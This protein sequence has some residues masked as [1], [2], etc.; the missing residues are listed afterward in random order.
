MGKVTMRQALTKSLNV[1][2]IKFAE[3]VGYDKVVELSQRLGLNEKIKPYPAI[4]LGSFEITPLEM[5]RAYTAFA[6]HGLLSELSPMLTIRDESGQQIYKP[7][8][9]QKQALTPQVAFM[10]TSLLQSVIDHGTGAGAR[11][12]GFALPAAGKT[13]TSRDGWF[14]GY[15]P[16]LLCIVWVGFDD[17]SE[18]NLSGAQSALPIWTEFMKKA[19]ILRP[20]KGESFVPPEGVNEVE[21]DPVTGLLATEACQKREKE[22]FIEGT[23]PK[24]ECYGAAYEKAVTAGVS[25]AAISTPLSKD[26]DKTP[27]RKN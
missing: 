9:D 18:L 23:E 10:I 5:S 17:N 11:T 1:A 25:P 22:Y 15:T 19:T 8:N 13:G 21:I 14:A 26:A 7:K 4:A 12:R 24:V 16:D 27:S 2:T 3:E 6:N 20:L